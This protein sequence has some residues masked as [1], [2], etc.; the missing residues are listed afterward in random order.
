MKQIK[1]RYNISKWD[2]LELNYWAITKCGNTSVKAA[3]LAKCGVKHQNKDEINAWVHDISNVKY[4]TSQ[5]A[6]N[7]GYVNFS[8]TRNPYDR[9]I[10]MYKDVKRRH[11]H[12]FR[13]I[14]VET[15]DDLLQYIKNTPEKD[16]DIHFKSQ[17]YFI[18]DK[19]GKIL[20]DIVY[21]I[22]K[23]NKIF[24]MQLNKLN[25]IV[26]DKKIILSKK[27]TTDIEILF[28]NDFE[29]LKYEKIP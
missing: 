8:V 9:F 4:I 11:N 21:D 13:E 3:L 22:D 17:S 12:F 20:V 18:C 2:S 26:T 23:I 25:E 10:S 6:I 27:Q 16:R 14:T 1:N 19:N 28:A 15:I 5:E 7:N 29:F 24:D